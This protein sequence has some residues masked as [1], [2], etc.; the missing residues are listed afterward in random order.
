VSSRGNLA[1]DATRRD[2]MHETFRSPRVNI[3][4]GLILGL[5][6][7]AAGM[8]ELFRSV[9]LPVDRVSDARLLAFVFLLVA[10]KAGWGAIRCCIECFTLEGR[11]LT[12]RSVFGT[13]VFELDRVARAEWLGRAGVLQLISASASTTIRFDV[14]ERQR[15]WQ[16]VEYLHAQ[17]PADVQTGWTAFDHHQAPPTGARPNDVLLTRRR[18]D[19]YFLAGILLTA[20]MGIWVVRVTGSLWVLVT[21]ICFWLML[22]TIRFVEPREGTYYRAWRIP[23][24]AARQGKWGLA[25][26]AGSFIGWTVY[27]SVNPFS[28]LPCPI[29]RGVLFGWLVVSCGVLF[30]FLLRVRREVL[31]FDADLAARDRAASTTTE[32]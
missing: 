5:L 23:P 29:F 24:G 6:F 16:L 12:Y 32:R 1:T 20:A 4:A 30:W 3:Y 26:L 22:V 17:I 25:W 31:R 15:R 14:L 8:Y 21:P 2:T 9:S 10:A 28:D 18:L 19:Y 7:G 11:R 13:A 27:L